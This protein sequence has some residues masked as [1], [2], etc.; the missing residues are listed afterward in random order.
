MVIFLKMWIL[1]LVGLAGGFFVVR[2]VYR[3]FGT[4]LVVEPPRKVILTLA[5]L[6]LLQAG[7]WLGGLQVVPP[8]GRYG[9]R[10]VAAVV[11]LISWGF[12]RYV[13]R[14]HFF[15]SEPFHIL[16]GQGGWSAILAF[17]WVMLTLP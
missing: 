6:P 4:D 14:E 1:A 12:L 10:L 15:G 2:Q 11:A 16:C 17:T 9:S 7:V 3:S 8:V 5:V 13:F